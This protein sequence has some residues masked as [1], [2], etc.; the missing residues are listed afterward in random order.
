MAYSSALKLEATCSSKTM[1]DFQWTTRYYGA[2]IATTL[3]AGRQRGRSS[4]PGKVKN[5]IFSTSSRPALGCTQ[6]TTQWV[7]E[8]LSSGV[9]RPVREADHSP[10]ASAEVKKM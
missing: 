10:P 1:V 9:K 6:L 7:P 8:A 3:R 2:G 4:S 5:F